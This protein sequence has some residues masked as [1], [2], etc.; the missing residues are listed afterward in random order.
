VRRLHSCSG[1]L[2]SVAALKRETIATT[3][4]RPCL[5][6]WERISL[7]ATGELSFCPSDWI[8]ASTVAD[9]RTTTIRETWQGE[10]Y[11]RLRRAHLTNDYSRHGFCGQCPDWA[12]TRWPGQGRSYADLVEDLAGT[13]A[14]TR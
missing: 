11:A 4:R 7:S 9:Y 6:P 2:V 1:S 3:E 10:F 8:H 12:S 13:E 5:Y 14:V